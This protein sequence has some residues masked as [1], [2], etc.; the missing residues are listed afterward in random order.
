MM[1]AF[2]KTFDITGWCYSRS[3]CRKAIAKN[4]IGSYDEER[5]KECKMKPSKQIDVE[6]RAN[7]IMSGKK[8]DDI[9]LL[10]GL[11]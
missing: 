5:L 9:I 4:K 2:K 1:R 10:G 8:T 6:K 3:I 7:L 11:Y